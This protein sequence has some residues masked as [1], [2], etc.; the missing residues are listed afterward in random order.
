VTT[1]AAVSLE[2]VRYVVK[3]DESGRRLIATLRDRLIEN[4]T[5]AG[6]LRSGRDEAWIAGAIAE[7]VRTTESSINGKTI[8]TVDKKAVQ[9]FANG[10]FD[11]LQQHATEASSR[12]GY[13]L[14]HTLF[15]IARAAGVHRIFLLIDQVEDFADADVPRKRR[16]M[17]VE[18]FRDLAI[19]TQPFGDMASYVLTLHPRAAHAIEEFWSLARLPQFDFG[20]RQNERTTVVLRALEKTEQAERLLTPY[21]NAFRAG[22]PPD[23]LFPFTRGAIEALRESARGRPGEILARAN[24]LIDDCAA[25]QAPLI[26]TAQVEAFFTDEAARPATTQRRRPFGSLQG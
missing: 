9:H 16:H 25:N 7:A 21:M 13:E 2:Q 12:S 23:P 14:L 4:L 17:E 19:E 20:K 15:V 8:A 24:R 18:R 11:M 3:P 10:A 5:N 22:T 6:E 26:D 1:L